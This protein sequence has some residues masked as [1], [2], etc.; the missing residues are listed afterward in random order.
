MVPL[1][2]GFTNAEERSP[3]EGENMPAGA[4]ISASFSKTDITVHLSNSFTPSTWKMV[5]SPF[6]GI[7]GVN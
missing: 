1:P 5:S 7:R 3:G 2:W 6:T 4:I